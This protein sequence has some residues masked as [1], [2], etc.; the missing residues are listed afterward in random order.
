MLLC[1]R[2]DRSDTVLLNYYALGPIVGVCIRD[3]GWGMGDGRWGMG[4]AGWAMRDGG[5]AMHSTC[6]CACVCARTL[7]AVSIVTISAFKGVTKFFDK[8]FPAAIPQ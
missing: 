3:A 5:W 8:L 7:C 1:A 2:A 6:T 4:D